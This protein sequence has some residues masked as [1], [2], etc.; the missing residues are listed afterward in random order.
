MGRT[1]NTDAGGK[2]IKAEVILKCSILVFR[3]A[4]LGSYYCPLTPFY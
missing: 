1:D 2:L 3:F 4:D